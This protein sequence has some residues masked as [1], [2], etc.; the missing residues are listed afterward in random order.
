[1]GEL[2]PT[3]FLGI[4]FDSKEHAQ[5]IN[6]ALNLE[7]ETQSKNIFNELTITVAYSRTYNFFHIQRRDALIFAKL[8]MKECSNF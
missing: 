3:Y 7:V 1:M 2:M 6:I 5:S 8:K 4:A